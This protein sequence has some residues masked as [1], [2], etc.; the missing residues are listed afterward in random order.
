MLYPFIVLLSFGIGVDKVK[1]QRNPEFGIRAGVNYASILSL[2]VVGEHSPRIG[3]VGG[4]YAVI[5]IP[6]SSFSFQ[7]EL[8]F[9][10]KGIEIESTNDVLKLSYL[11]LPLFARFDFAEESHLS[12]HLLLGPYVAFN[13]AK[14]EDPNA[15]IN[16]TLFGLAI[17]AGIDINRINVGIRYSQGISNVYT[18]SVEGRNSVGS[19]VVGYQF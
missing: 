17:G 16:K 14:E 19:I 5:P 7:P 3:F 15:S 10:Q 6:S 1:A 18:G 2:P 11:Q 8:L 13:I 12:P 9:T 4:A